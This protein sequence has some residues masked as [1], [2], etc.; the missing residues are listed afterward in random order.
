MDT[1]DY[2][3]I[4]D[5]K[6]FVKIGKKYFVFEKGLDFWYKS[7]NAEAALKWKRILIYDHPELLFKDWTIGV[8]DSVYLELKMARLLRLP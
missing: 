1:Q 2:Q 8:P 7:G 5:G 3:L 4:H 6:W